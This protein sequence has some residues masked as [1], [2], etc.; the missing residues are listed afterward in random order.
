MSTIT[1]YWWRQKAK[2]PGIHHESRWTP[3]RWSEYD[4]RVE[5]RWGFPGL[6]KSWGYSIRMYTVYPKSSICRRIVHDKASVLGIPHLWK[7]PHQSISIIYIVLREN[8]QKTMDWVGC[9]H[10]KI[11]GVHLSERCVTHWGFG[12]WEHPRPRPQASLRHGAM[13]TSLARRAVGFAQRT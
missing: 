8:R 3:Q 4:D 7:H 12:W 13:G 6:P 9:S 11:E 1:M 2:K 5:S 10:E